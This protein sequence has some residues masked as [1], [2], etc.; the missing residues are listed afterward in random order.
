MACACIFKK[1]E[2]KDSI[3][4]TG[5]KG[6]KSGFWSILAKNKTKRK[7]ERKKVRCRMRQRIVSMQL[8]GTICSQ[9]RDISAV[10]PTIH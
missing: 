2:G 3:S 8:K 7:E 1:K 9:Q 4:L 5:I 10:N 6:Q